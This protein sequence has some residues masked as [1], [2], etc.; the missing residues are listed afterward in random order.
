MIYKERSVIPN[1]RSDIVVEFPGQKPF[2]I[3]VV[4]THDLEEDTRRR[5][6]ESGY[7]VVVR[8][9]TWENLEEL[10]DECTAD[11]TVNGVGWKCE[12]CKEQDKARRSR[13]A[14]D[15]AREKQRLDTLER[16]KKVVDAALAKLVRRR[17]PKPRFRPWYEVYK[18]SWDLVSEPIKMFPRVQRAV[19]TNATI[20]TELGFEQHNPSKPYRFRYR[21]RNKP[22]VFIYAD[23]GGS[24]VVK[25]YDD[26]AAMLYAPDIDDEELKQYAVSVFGRK[27]EE[28][29]VSVRVGFESSVVFESRNVDL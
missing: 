12:D 2:L 10:S 5:Y 11:D 22:R 15:R 1:T 14:E 20:L 27:L 16:R 4:N 9:V 8:K 19:F 3:E 25:I 29:G 28:S 24:D 7:R 26:T 21:I 17:N 6:E 23:L 18:P 13:K